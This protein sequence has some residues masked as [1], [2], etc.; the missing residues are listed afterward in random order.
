M[1]RKRS[2]T[3]AYMGSF[4]EHLWNGNYPSLFLEI[5]S[6]STFWSTRVCYKGLP[7]TLCFHFMLEM[8]FSNNKQRAR[9]QE[10]YKMSLDVSDLQSRHSA[11]HKTAGFDHTHTRVQMYKNCG[12]HTHW[13]KSFR[14]MYIMHPSF[15]NALRDP[16]DH[17][18]F[19]V[20]HG[21]LTSFFFCSFFKCSWMDST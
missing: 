3:W 15:I 18:V 4:L 21:F 8:W 17:W 6:R 9:V 5:M 19:F 11:R 16:E 7:F 14:F 20:L 2:S 10:Q 12:P 13:A 1:I